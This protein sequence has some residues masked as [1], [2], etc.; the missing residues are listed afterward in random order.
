MSKWKYTYVITKNGMFF[1]W[2]KYR[3]HLTW[4]K[5]KEKWQ[6]RFLFSIADW[7]GYKDFKKQFKNIC[8]QAQK[9]ELPLFTIYNKDEN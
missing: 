5:N 9:M 6:D 2:W 8:I 3:I 7:L 1:E 4:Q